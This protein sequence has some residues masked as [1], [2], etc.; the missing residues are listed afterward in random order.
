MS[1]HLELNPDWVSSDDDFILLQ[2]GTNDRL[3]DGQ[4]TYTY[5]ANFIRKMRSA[6]RKVILM[7]SIPASASNDNKTDVGYFRNMEDEASEIR[8]LSARHGSSIYQ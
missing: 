1:K 7:A 2:L 5:Q 3:N 6:G 4:S 8:A